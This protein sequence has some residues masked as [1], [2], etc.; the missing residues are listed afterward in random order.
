M[1]RD[2]IT[3]TSNERGLNISHTIL[4]IHIKDQLHF[5]HASSAAGRVVLSEITLNRYLLAKRSR[6]GIIVCRAI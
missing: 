5:L 3:M 2:I 1:D 4:S 6:T